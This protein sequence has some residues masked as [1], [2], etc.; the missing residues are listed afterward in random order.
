MGSEIVKVLTIATT[1]LGYEGIT[2]VIMNYYRNIDSSKIKMDFLIT[3]GTMEWV[4]DEI[5]SQGGTIYELP[6]RNKNPLL[7]IIRLKALLR[8]KN[9]QIVHVHGNSSTM[10]FDIFAARLAK[11]PVRIAHTHSTGC[12]SKVVH[13][14][15]KPLLNTSITNA[16]ACS[17][18]AGDNIFTLPYT[19]INNG[20]DVK[21]FFYNQEI[22]R[23]Y[24]DELQLNNKFV[25]GHIGYFSDVKNHSYIIDIFNEVF[26]LNRNSSLLLVGDGNQKK[27][28][29]EKVQRLG[30]EDVVL[31]L[32]KRSD[33]SSLLQSMDVFIL[34]SKY[35]GL[36]V[37]VIEA[38]A[39]GLQ[40]FISDTITHET[41]ITEKVKYLSINKP[42][43]LW[44]KEL[45]KYNNNYCRDDDNL[46][47]MQS[48]FNIQKEIKNLQS[49][50]LRAMGVNTNENY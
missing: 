48:K 4:K 24:R 25:I 20:I 23:V 39:A 32:G 36:P 2:S 35:E 47:I 41:Q 43:L 15:L 33:V 17:S 44:A 50:Y 40:C 10:F 42:A 11:V 13:N 21:K 49:C 31:F 29:Q 46:K 37:S 22:R 34:P 18:S 27:V 5:R 8:I 9:Y 16:F 7:Y 19:I 14:L 30:L 38:Q 6:M 1:P 3:S 28:I 12:S 45:L 26:K